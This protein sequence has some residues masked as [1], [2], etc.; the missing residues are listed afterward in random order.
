MPGDGEGEGV[1]G[2]VIFFTNNP[3]LKKL[4]WGG[5]GRGG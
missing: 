5:G 2:L 1:L 4:F 3:K